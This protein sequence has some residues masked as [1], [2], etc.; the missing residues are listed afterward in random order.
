MHNIFYQAKLTTNH[1]FDKKTK[2]HTNKTGVKWSTSVTR[3]QAEY[4]WMNATHHHVTTVN[5]LFLPNDM[6]S[7]CCKLSIINKRRVTTELLQCFAWLEAVNPTHPLHYITAV[8][9]TT[10]WWT[11]ILYEALNTGTASTAD[12]MNHPAVTD[13][14]SQSYVP[15]MVLNFHLDCFSTFWYTCS[16]TF[17]H[18][19]WKLPIQGQIFR[20]LG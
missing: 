8:D 14:R 5:H 1:Y 4:R 20:G 10:P 18:F 19:G 3:V 13:S 15:N 16:F 12:D 11:L 17:H 9:T 6:V 2:F 7:I